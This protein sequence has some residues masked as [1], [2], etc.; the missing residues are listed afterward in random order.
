MEGAAELMSDPERRR[1]NIFEVL[2]ELIFHL[3]TTKS[4]FTLLIVSSFILAPLAIIVAA[5]ITL[6]PAFLAVLLN[7]LPAVGTIMIAFIGI[8]VVLSAVWLAIGI[9][10]RAFFSSWNTRFSLFMSLR[11]RID[12]EL[13]EAGSG[14]ERELDGKRRDGRDED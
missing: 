6:H 3:N 12:R 10:E 1:N 4:M 8:T 9:K 2:D 13:E 5:V 14:E 11:E 7:R